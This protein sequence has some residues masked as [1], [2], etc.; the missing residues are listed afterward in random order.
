LRFYLIKIYKFPQNM[1]EL[2]QYI[3]SFFGVTATGDLKTIVSFFELNVIKKGAFLLK[4]GKRCDKL[5]FVQSGFLRM[6]AA[7]DDKEVTQWISTKGSFSTDLSSFIFETPS[8]WTIQALVDTELYTIT[9]EDYKKIG[10]LI[11]K[12]K[13]LEKLFLV[14]AFTIVEDRIF[15]HLSMTAEERYHYHFENNRELFNQVPLQFIA[16][17]LGMTPETFSRIRKKQLL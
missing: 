1:T 7:T 3:K 9:K 4:S 10:Q 5:S 2:E 17:M 8:R 14:Q 15:R 13:D 16:S 6:F 12:W 11:P